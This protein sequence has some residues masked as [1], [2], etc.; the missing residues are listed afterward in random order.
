MERNHVR[1]RQD[2]EVMFPRSRLLFCSVAAAGRLFVEFIVF[3]RTMVVD[4]VGFHGGI[5]AVVGFIA[6]FRI[7]YC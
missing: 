6:D 5:V 7:H 4:A 2:I 1:N 3:R